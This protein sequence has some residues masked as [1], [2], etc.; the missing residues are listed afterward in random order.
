[1]LFSVCAIYLAKN[2]VLKEEKGKPQT[3]NISSIY[4]QQRT[5]FKDI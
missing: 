4:N 3:K 1:M 5:S 2:T